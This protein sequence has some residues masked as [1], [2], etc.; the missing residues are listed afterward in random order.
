[1]FTKINI[2]NKITEDLSIFLPFKPIPD[3]TLMTITPKQS[4]IAVL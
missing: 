3:T 4:L 1:M 2:P